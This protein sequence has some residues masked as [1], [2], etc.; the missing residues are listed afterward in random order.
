MVSITLALTGVLYR[1]SDS[2]LLSLSFS[3][4]DLSAE[5]R[6]EGYNDRAKIC[7]SVRCKWHLFYSVIGIGV[8]TTPFLHTSYGR[9]SYVDFSTLMLEIHSPF[10]LL[11]SIYLSL[12]FVFAFFC[13]VP[14]R[15]TIFA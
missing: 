5:T 14:V 9:I 11:S 3:F 8:G 10:S 6:L 13:I 12:L 1:Q 7:M 4:S 2:V 15:C